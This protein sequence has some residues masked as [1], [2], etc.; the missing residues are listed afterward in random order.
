MT[1]EIVRY[2][3]RGS[4]KNPA[5]GF[6]RGTGTAFLT[7]TLVELD[8]DCCDILL[9]HVTPGNRSR[10]DLALQRYQLQAPHNAPDTPIHGYG[11]I[12]RGV[13]DCREHHPLRRRESG[14]AAAVVASCL[15]TTSTGP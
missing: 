3:W 5:I 1:A 13:S 11:C 4:R 7:F 9:H 15:P 6:G 8:E 10:I 12:D 14:D 2:A